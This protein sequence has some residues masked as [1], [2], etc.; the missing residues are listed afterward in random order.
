MLAE[1][2]IKAINK[3]DSQEEFNLLLDK[4]KLSSAPLEIREA[5]IEELKK[6]KKMFYISEKADLTEVYLD[7]IAGQADIDDIV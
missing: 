3:V 5:A 1:G 2:I 4:F 7:I 6:R